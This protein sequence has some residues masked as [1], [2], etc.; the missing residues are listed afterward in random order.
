M[1]NKVP[2]RQVSFCSWFNTKCCVQ[3]NSD[4]ACSGWCFKLSLIRPNVLSVHKLL[5]LKWA[6]TLLVQHKLLRTKVSRFSLFRLVLKV[7]LIRPYVN[8][9]THT[10]SPQMGTNV[11]SSRQVAITLFASYFLSWGKKV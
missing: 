2:Y 4:S 7:S 1:I 10:A 11:I 3:K 5:H 8:F 9:W 6:P